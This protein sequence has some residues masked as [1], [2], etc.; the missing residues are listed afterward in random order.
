MDFKILL[1]DFLQSIFFCKKCEDDS[2]SMQNKSILQAQTNFRVGISVI[3]ILAIKHK[4]KKNIG[5][6]F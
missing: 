4:S 1:P 2:W 5:H 3:F 6:M